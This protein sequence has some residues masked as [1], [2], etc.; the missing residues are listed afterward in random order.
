M[1]EAL[2]VC[3]KNDN[4][5]RPLPLVKKRAV[6]F[7]ADT[8]GG[9]T[10][11]EAEGAWINPDTGD[12]QQEPVWEFTVACHDTVTVR[13]LLHSIAVEIGLQADQHSMYLRYPSGNVEIIEIAR[14]E[15]ALVG[16]A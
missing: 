12:V 9:C 5:G 4:D 1:R 3:P 14:A 2:I 7:L 6:R 15:A 16:A 13:S 8:F 11:R 10:V